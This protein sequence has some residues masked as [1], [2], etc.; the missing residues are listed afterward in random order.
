MILS[1]R[2]RKARRKRPWERKI[3]VKP[4]PS[5][6]MLYDDAMEQFAFE[7]VVF[8]DLPSDVDR[9]NPRGFVVAHGGPEEPL[10]EI[11]SGV[12]RDEPDAR[13]RVTFATGRPIRNGR[14][15]RRAIDEYFETHNYE[16]WLDEWR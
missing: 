13:V 15:L 10:R 9:T 16:E 3:P 12:L 14:E 11:W 4:G 6:P 7:W 2:H 8:V 5:E 1:E